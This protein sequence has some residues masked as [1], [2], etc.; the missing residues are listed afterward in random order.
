MFRLLCGASIVILVLPKN[1]R[2]KISLLLVCGSKSTKN[3]DKGS[4]VYFVTGLLYI[5]LTFA[6]STGT[7]TLSA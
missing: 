2:L 6:Y 7:V 3:S 1:W 5:F 4:F